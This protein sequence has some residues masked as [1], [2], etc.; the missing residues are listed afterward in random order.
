MAF[1]DFINT[2]IYTYP[3]VSADK[4][5]TATYSSTGT[6]WDARVKTNNKVITNM[7]GVD[8]TPDIKVSLEGD[9]N[10][11]I[12][13]KLVYASDTYEINRIY[14]PQGVRVV[15]HTTIYATK[16]G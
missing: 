12:K 8:I 2:S 7:Q 14:K 11:D 10:I 15:H 5:S 13:D 6:S 1:N 9:A 3:Y 16:V 4:Y